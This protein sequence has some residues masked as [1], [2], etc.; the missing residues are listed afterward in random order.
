MEKNNIS[1]LLKNACTDSVGLLPTGFLCQSLGVLNP[2]EAI[3]IPGATELGDAIHIMKEKKIG[4]L[5][6]S[7]PDQRLAGIFTERDVLLRAFGKDPSTFVRDCMT[8]NPTTASLMDPIAYALNLMSH[9][10]FRHV[11]LTDHDSHEVVGIIS[12]KDIIDYISHKM[13]ESLLAI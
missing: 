1:A 9:G 10:G 13:T 2:P 5:I 3:A 12:V 6:I 4:C 11:P 8:K 7:E